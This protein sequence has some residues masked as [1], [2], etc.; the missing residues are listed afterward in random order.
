MLRF[1]AKDIFGDDMELFFWEEMEFSSEEEIPA[2]SLKVTLWGEYLQELCEVSLYENEELLFEG[3]VDEQTVSVSDKVQ[4]SIVARSFTGV[5]LDNEAYPKTYIKPDTKLIFSRYLEPYGIKS[6]VGENKIFPG[7]FKV[8]K[9]ISCFAAAV[10]FA[11]EVYGCMPRI[12]GKVIF[13]EKDKAPGKLVFSNTDGLTY[14]KLSYTRNRYRL[15]SSVRAK[16]K[17]GGDYSVVVRNPKA[18]HK[19]IKREKYLNAIPRGRAG[20]NSAD[21]YISEA[22]SKYEVLTLITN[23]RCLG[24]V[25][26]DASIASE[27]KSL[28]DGFYISAVR[29]I[30][31]SN[32]EETK[33]TLRRRQA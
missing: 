22:D 11:K 28:L 31:D 18:T 26:F 16:V 20:L 29:Y 14:K 32:K 3:L 27:C 9:G 2:D 7:E 1:F 8:E 33:L 15:I 10:K 24:V 19:G 21:N 4:T 25:G 30:F 5:L 6:F 23:E 17:N 12:K 13:F